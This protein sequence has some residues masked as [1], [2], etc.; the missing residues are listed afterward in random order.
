MM[1]EDFQWPKTEAALRIAARVLDEEEVWQVR[2]IMIR[3][4]EEN[5]GNWE[6]MSRAVLSYLKGEVDLDPES[7]IYWDKIK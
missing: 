7:D 6:I 2:E 3:A 4:W 5:D 1:R